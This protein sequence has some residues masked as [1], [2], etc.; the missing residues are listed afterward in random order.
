MTIAGRS[1]DSI[2][3][4][5]PG[6]FERF[7]TNRTPSSLGYYW[8]SDLAHVCQQ[9]LEVLSLLLPFSFSRSQTHSLLIL[10]ASLLIT[11]KANK[12]L[13]FC[14]LQSSISDGCSVTSLKGFCRG[15]E[16]TA[17]SSDFSH[18]MKFAEGTQRLW[19]S[20]KPDVVCLCEILSS[21]NGKHLFHLYSSAHNVCSV[22][23]FFHIKSHTCRRSH[24]IS[25]KN[26]KTM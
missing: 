26:A 18:T 20:T 5:T 6:P 10:S 19:C 16:G 1:F 7:R 13:I 17:A 14:R 2:V 12:V 23:S 8:P 25:E 22:G 24:E 9:P 3:E 15:L 21:M 11:K 4:K